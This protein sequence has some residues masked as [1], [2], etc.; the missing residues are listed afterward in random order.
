[1]TSKTDNNNVITT[2]NG[3]EVY[4]SDISVLCSEYESQFDDLEER[5]NK[6]MFFT[7]LITYINRHLFKNITSIKYNNDYNALNDLFFECFIPLC[8]KYNKTIT[9]QNFCLMT[10]IDNGML[11]VILSGTHNDGSRVKPETVETV[12][13][14]KSACESALIDSGMSGNPVFSIFALKA[15]HGW[16]EEPQRLEIVGTNAPQATPEQ[17]AEKYRDA[18]RPELPEL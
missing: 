13:K 18:K 17:I 12:K 7:G 9:L 8:A 6:P 1:M 3:I 14:W 16:K 11:S 15:G 2:Y 5:K 4:Y 10:G